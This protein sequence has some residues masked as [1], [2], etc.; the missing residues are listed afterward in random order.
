MRGIIGTNHALEMEHDY[1]DLRTY[2]IRIEAGYIML[3]MYV[4][5]FKCSEMRMD[6]W[7]IISNIAAL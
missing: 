7:R 3:T 2:E 1:S 4:D 6:H 5:G